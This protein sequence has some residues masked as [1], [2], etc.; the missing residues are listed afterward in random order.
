[1]HLC[2]KTLVL[3]PSNVQIHRQVLLNNA[4]ISK[5]KKTTSCELLQTHD[6]IISRGDNNRGE[7]DLIKMHIATRLDAAPVAA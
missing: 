2:N 6:T 4:K 5:E 3:M 7:T 1:M